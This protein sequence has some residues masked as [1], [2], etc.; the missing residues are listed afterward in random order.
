MTT[1]AE[2]SLR[3][4]AQALETLETLD[5]APDSVCSYLAGYAEGLIAARDQQRAQIGA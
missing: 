1:T 2:R 4:L 3:S 5:T